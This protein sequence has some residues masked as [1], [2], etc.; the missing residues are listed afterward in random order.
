MHL[1]QRG[2]LIPVGAGVR[3]VDPGR[4]LVVELHEHGLLP[5]DSADDGV[6]VGLTRL[7][8]L[9][10]NAAPVP[11]MLGTPPYMLGTPPVPWA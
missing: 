5:E 9:G 10:V 3:I 7:E 8:L 6:E 2:E 4:V 1:A 11:C